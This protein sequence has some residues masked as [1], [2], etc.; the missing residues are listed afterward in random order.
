ME[1]REELD[2][3]RSLL[4]HPKWKELCEYAESQ[5][6]IRVA[7]VLNGMDNIREEDKQRGEVL[8]IMLFVEFPK[9]IVET[10]EVELDSNKEE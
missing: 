10:L 2:A 1:I 3:W 9:T 7:S 4:S 6:A 8:G 5:R